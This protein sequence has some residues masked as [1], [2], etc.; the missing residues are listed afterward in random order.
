MKLHLAASVLERLDVRA[1]PKKA[2]EKAFKFM[3]GVGIDQVCE[4]LNPTARWALSLLPGH[5]QK[6]QI[7]DWWVIDLSVLY[8][9]L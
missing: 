3:C 6:A 7:D 4:G 9:D 2:I 8:I 1:V 5:S